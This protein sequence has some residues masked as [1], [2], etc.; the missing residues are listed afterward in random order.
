MINVNG[1]NSESRGVYFQA[2]KIYASVQFMLSLIFV[3]TYF[4]IAVQFMLS[5]IFYGNKIYI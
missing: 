5:L 1:R 2:S 4:F 3:V